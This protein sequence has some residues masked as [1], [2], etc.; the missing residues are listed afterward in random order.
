MAILTTVVGAICALAPQ[1][2][3]S[4]VPVAGNPFH[5]AEAFPKSATFLASWNP[6]VDTPWP[7][8]VEALPRELQSTLPRLGRFVSDYLELSHAELNAVLEARG[9][10]GIWSETS[11]EHGVG[12]MLLLDCGNDADRLVAALERVTGE[13]LDAGLKIAT[14]RSPTGLDVAF[15]RHRD[16][17]LFG[18]STEVLE[19]ATIRLERAP[20][21]S[22][23]AHDNIRFQ[24]FLSQCKEDVSSGDSFVSAYVDVSNLLD[25]W[26]SSTPTA[27]RDRA[28]SIRDAL[29][30]GQV[31]ALGY[32]AR[33]AGNKTHEHVRV[34]F[35]E[36]RN[37]VPALLAGPGGKLE[38]DVAD[39]VPAET[40]SLTVFH[41]DTDA[42]LT[43]ALDC[44]SAVDANASN[45]FRSMLR[46][47]SA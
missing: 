41:L 5:R 39:F 6:T 26:I 36:P 31:F 13:K 34:C 18:S 21:A 46:T 11:N 33:N 45:G 12:W 1:Q 23:S 42:L 17:L 29:K 2:T 44:L 47:V 43:T 3:P 16:T 37:G 15:G 40:P 25:A 38:T 8:I 9:S 27:D 19:E 22:Q 14:L 4:S 28:V 10:F 35:P 7:R 32:F 20:N 24:R 30:L